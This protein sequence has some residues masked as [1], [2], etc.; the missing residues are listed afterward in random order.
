MYNL[1]FFAINV[2]LLWAGVNL[3]IE[4]ISILFVIL[5]A[6]LAKAAKKIKP[7]RL[8]TFGLLA[9]AIAKAWSK[10]WTGL[11]AF[12]FLY[13][14][15]CQWKVKIHQIQ[16]KMV[17]ASWFYLKKKKEKLMII[18]K[19]SYSHTDTWHMQCQIDASSHL[20][21]ILITWKHAIS[22]FRNVCLIW[23]IR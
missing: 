20:V 8:M 1:P 18:C 23:Q 21:A 4:S 2:N 7:T 6:I 11:A 22:L 16:R 12:K 15:S 3:A 13:W 14:I 9:Q 17:S 5:R 19:G 10:L